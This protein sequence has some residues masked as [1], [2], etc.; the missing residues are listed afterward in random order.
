VGDV[1]D[2]TGGME[3]YADGILLEANE[4]T[5]DESAMTGEGDPITKNTLDVCIKRKEYLEKNGEKNLA[6]K[7][8]VPSPI[9]MSGTSILT[10]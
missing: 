2:I 9:L 7:H 5:I 1:V 3:I 4:I 6:D 10:G 8:L